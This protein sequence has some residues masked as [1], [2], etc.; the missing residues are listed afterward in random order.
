MSQTIGAAAAAQLVPPGSRVYLAG[1]A[2]EPAAILDA[3]AQD[4]GLWQG[5]TLT[6]VFIPGVNERDL[7][8]I[9]TAT[10]VETFFVTGGLRRGVAAATVAVLPMHYTQIWR[11]L[12]APKAIDVAFVQVAPSDRSDRFSLGIAADFT[13]AVV[14]SGARLV[15]VVN[16]AMPRV[17]SAPAIPRERFAALVETDTPLVSYA[18]GSIGPEIAAIARQ[19]VSAI[20]DGATLQLGLGKLQSAVLA[21]LHG[22]R[23]LGFH[24]GMISDGILPHRAAGTFTRGI[25]TGVAIGSRTLYDAMETSDDLV[26][27]PVGETHAIAILAGIPRLVA[28]NS[29]LEVDL[30]GQANADTLAG[31]P[32]SGHGGMLDFIRGA[33]AS[34]GGRSFLALAATARGG[35][36]R[37]RPRLPPGTP[38]TVPRSDVDMVVTEHG[39]ASLRDG[40][41]AQRAARLIAIAA[42]QHREALAQAWHEGGG[43]AGA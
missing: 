10:R 12:S 1:C 38:V 30:F 43:G 41:V 21:V 25:T 8:A 17:P 11:W 2:G 32:I 35:E 20:P 7:T 24:A 31:R 26:F 39:I 23:D 34:Q 18:S 16:T 33:A 14:A 13:T 5:V 29:V 4:P 28:I 36:S 3:V 9:G 42:P 40:S 27:R 19:I 37:I 6:G 22:R 15:G